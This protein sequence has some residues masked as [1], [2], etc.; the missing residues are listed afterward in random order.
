MRKRSV[1][2]SCRPECNLR[3]ISEVRKGSLLRSDEINY[4]P[5]LLRPHQTLF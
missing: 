1:S 2:P 3:D 4:A 5:N